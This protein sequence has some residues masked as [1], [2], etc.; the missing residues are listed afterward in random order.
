MC[1]THANYE[2]TTSTALMTDTQAYFI[3]SHTLNRRSF[4]E[5]WR[6]TVCMNNT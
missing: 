2:D 6:M 5:L 1:G 4:L 3:H